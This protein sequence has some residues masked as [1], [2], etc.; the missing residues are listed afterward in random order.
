MKLKI[1]SI[2]AVCALT[3]TSCNDVL[4]RPPFTSME[5]DTFWTGEDLRRRNFCGQYLTPRV[6]RRKH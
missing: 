2:L 3:L 4:D 5:D 6:V 1:F